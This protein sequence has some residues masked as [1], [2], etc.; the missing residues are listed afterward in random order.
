MPVL[1][2]S[3]HTGNVGHEWWLMQVNRPLPTGK[4]QPNFEVH[5]YWLEQDIVKDDEAIS[6]S[7]ED[8]REIKVKYASVIKDKDGDP[9]IIPSD[10]FCAGWDTSKTVYCLSSE[11]CSILDELL[12]QTLTEVEDNNVPRI[13][14]STTL[15]EEAEEYCEQ[16]PGTSRSRSISRRGKEYRSYKD[17]INNA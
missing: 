16:L 10:L 6:Y 3:E 12:D 14:E 15:D 13:L 9:F 8:S 11:L 1:G 5:G 4:W 17:M 7:L 2:E